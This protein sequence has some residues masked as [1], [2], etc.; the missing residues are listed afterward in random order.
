MDT[1]HIKISDYNYDLADWQEGYYRTLGRF[2][3]QIGKE[4]REG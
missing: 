2:L 1:K 3:L 4:L